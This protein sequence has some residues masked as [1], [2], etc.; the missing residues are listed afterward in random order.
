MIL[1]M[2]VKNLITWKIWSNNNVLDLVKQKGFYPYEHMRDF[3]KIKEQL[4]SEKKFYSSFTGNNC[5]YSLKK[6]RDVEF[7]IFLIEIV[8]PTIIFEILWPKT[9][10]EAIQVFRH[11]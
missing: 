3:E 10:I 4:P 1:I 9:I 7:L 11:K 5:I 6:V 8:S 2:W